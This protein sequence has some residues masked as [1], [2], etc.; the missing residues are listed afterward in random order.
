MRSGSRRRHA[1][2]EPSPWRRGRG[3]RGSLR[4]RPPPTPRPATVHGA[5]GSSDFYRDDIF[6]N[7]KFNDVV[8]DSDTVRVFSLDPS[9]KTVDGSYV[10]KY[11]YQIN[12]NY[13]SVTGELSEESAL[14][15]TDNN[16][17]NAKFNYWGSATPDPANFKY[18]LE[19][20]LYIDYSEFFGSKEALEDAIANLQ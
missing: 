6:V 7:V 14:V 10:F 12:C 13:N 19:P 1:G 15:F 9:V 5:D 2:P 4:G 17:L 11:N 16:K 18:G 20:S 8:I 3:S